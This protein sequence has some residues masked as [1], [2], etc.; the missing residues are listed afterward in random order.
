MIF[1]VLIKDLIVAAILLFVG[2]AVGMQHGER[3]GKEQ[4]TH[5]FHTYKK[6]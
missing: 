4:A 3:I 2:Y 5:W 1:N 6:D